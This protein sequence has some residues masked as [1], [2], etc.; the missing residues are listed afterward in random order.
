MYKS[1][2]MPIEVS[3]TTVGKKRKK[4]RDIV[5]VICPTPLSQSMGLSHAKPIYVNM[6]DVSVDWN[7]TSPGFEMLHNRGIL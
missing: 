6:G 4:T 2:L 7:K 3:Y 5:G 1:M